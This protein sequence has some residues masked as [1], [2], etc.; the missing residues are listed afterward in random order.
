MN[1]PLSTGP[2]LGLILLC[3]VTSVQALP[4]CMHVMSYHQGYEW[5][6]GIE[7]GVEKVLA[8]KCQL[9]KFYMDS[10]RNTS[11]DF[12]QKKA[13][14]AKNAIDA[15]QPDV[16]IVS[17]DNAS[18]YLVQTYYK[19]A[20]TPFV[21]NGVN[22]TAEVYG[23]P[24][25]NATGMVEVAPVRTMLEIAQRNTSNVSKVSF[26]SADVLTEHKDFQ[27]YERIYGRAGITVTPIFVKNM[28][29]WQTGF[30]DAQAADLIILGNNAGINDWDSKRALRFVKENGKTLTITTY[31]WMM[32]YT[33]LG[34]SKLASEQGEWA[35]EV[36][37]EVLS[38]TDIAEIP[39]TV[40][41]RWVFYQN[42]LLLLKAGIDIDDITSHKAIAK[43]WSNEK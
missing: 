13:L 17:D 36:A 29:D 43:E 41:R 34:V 42:K 27:Q 5:N 1:R 28:A 40:N 11:T 39:I 25:K 24:Y 2:G 31:Q 16:V 19:N 9:K 4:R 26:L 22:W 8:G 21:F 3:V 10:K 6:D 18:G 15:Y 20:D 33:M 37:L 7:Q 14:Q 32:P 12:I 38:G 30:N 35:A 23:Y